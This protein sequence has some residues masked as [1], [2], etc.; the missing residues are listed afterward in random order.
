MVFHNLSG[1]LN[2]NRRGLYPILGML[3][4]AAVNLLLPPGS[5]R[6]LNIMWSE[7]APQSRPWW[8]VCPRRY[9]VEFEFVRVDTTKNHRLGA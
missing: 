9:Y 8:A 3:Q 6:L 5:S 4:K 1:K 7:L 2:I